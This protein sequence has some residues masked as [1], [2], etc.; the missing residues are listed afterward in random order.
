MSE[1]VCVGV[2]VC[3]CV[4][5][6]KLI[7]LFNNLVRGVCLP[8]ETIFF[9]FLLLSFLLCMRTGMRVSE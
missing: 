6:G 8:G 9:L 2:C 1:L 7:S 5:R 3:V 4:G